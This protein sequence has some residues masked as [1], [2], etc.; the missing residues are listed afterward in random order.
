MIFV[1]FL[2][3]LTKELIDIVFLLLMRAQLLGMLIFNIVL[4]L[5][6][7][8]FLLFRRLRHWALDQLDVFFCTVVG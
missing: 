3:L 2:I 5:L 6:F 8:K 1:I 7:L 4:I